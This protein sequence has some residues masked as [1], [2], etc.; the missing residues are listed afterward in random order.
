MK[1]FLRRISQRTNYYLSGPRNSIITSAKDSSTP[2]YVFQETVRGISNVAN[3]EE[4][5][6][7]SRDANVSKCLHRPWQ[8]LNPKPITIGEDA[9]LTISAADASMQDVVPS[10]PITKESSN[11]HETINM[12]ARLLGW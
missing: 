8:T 12:C 3:A 5:W 11:A 2:G 4:Q 6:K 10:T 7:Q 1:L 9:L